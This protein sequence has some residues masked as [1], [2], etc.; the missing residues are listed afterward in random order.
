MGDS[1]RRM[2]GPAGTFGF[3]AKREPRGF[4]AE[5]L[6]H[7][8]E[9]V[10]REDGKSYTLAQVADAINTAAGERIGSTAYVQQLKVG[11]SD[12]PTYK[13]IVGLSRFF[14]VSP[15]YFFEDADL[16]RGMVPAELAVAVSNEDVREIA[17]DAA[18]LS[19]Q[20]LESVKQLI[21]NARALEDRPA[22]RRRSRKPSSE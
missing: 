22:P 3:M 8:F 1:L 21:A 19:K 18:G 5:R 12:N 4:I 20:S 11:D 7:L 16:E 13:V 2:E 6:T 17:V 14:G 15:M 10:L 9:T